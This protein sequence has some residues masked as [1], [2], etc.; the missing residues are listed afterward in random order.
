MFGYVR[1]FKPAITMGEYE[2]YKG[3]YCTLCKRLGKRYGVLSRFTLSY[4]MTF[5]ALLEMAL[6]EEDPAFCPSRCSFNPAKRCLK[7]QHTPALDRAADIGTILTYYK[8]KDT[9]A[10]E[11][12]GKKIGA[13]CLYPFA[14]IAHKRAKKRRPADDTLV[15]EMMARQAALETE[16]CPSVDRAAEPFALMLQHMAAATAAN[17][18]QKRILERFGYCLGRWVYLTDAV[19]DLAED[20]RKGRYNPYAAARQLTAADTEGIAA[21][22]RYA[23]GSLNACLAECIAA[24]NLLEICRFDGILRNILE[25][26]MPHTQKRVIAGEEQEH[27]RSL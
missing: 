20:L 8:L 2:Q 7:A 6:A 12:I 27:E 15:A 3:I 25:K 18:E 23:E 16:G 24:Y 10:D 1:L 14:A 19:D 9:L 22:R 4:D 11:G 17:D 5:L 21:T 13:V 26:G